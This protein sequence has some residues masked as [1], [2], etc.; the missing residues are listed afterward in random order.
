MKFLAIPVCLV[1][2]GATVWLGFDYVFGFIPWTVKKVAVWDKPVATAQHV[3]GTEVKTD[4]AS[5]P[6]IPEGRDPVRQTWLWSKL[7]HKFPGLGQGI[8]A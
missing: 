5:S 1:L 3:Q 6:P 4:A 7:M 2:F 8:Y